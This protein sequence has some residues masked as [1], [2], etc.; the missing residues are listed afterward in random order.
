MRWFNLL[1]KRNV[2]TKFFPK[3]KKGKSKP[4]KTIQYKIQF[5]FL[6]EKKF[7]IDFIFLPDYVAH[8]IIKEFWK[9]SHF[10]KM[11]ADFLL[12]GQN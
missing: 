11:T 8:D 1:S 5:N 2:E 3:D 10:E 4:L 9:N 6:I 7:K 12:K